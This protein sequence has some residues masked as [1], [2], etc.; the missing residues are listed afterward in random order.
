M[1]LLLILD[2]DTLLPAQ[3][4]EL[5]ASIQRA[6]VTAYVDITNTII[7]WHVDKLE[8]GTFRC[9]AMLCCRRL[10]LCAPDGSLSVQKHHASSCRG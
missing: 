4:N 9:G 10:C 5:V 7:F 6:T 2:A 3:A 1:Y 8:W